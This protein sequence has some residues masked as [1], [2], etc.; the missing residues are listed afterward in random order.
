[1]NPNKVLNE[2]EIGESIT[3]LFE[4]EEAINLVYDG[5]S[6][7]AGGERVK[8]FV[9]EDTDTRYAI[10]ENEL[11]ENISIN[12]IHIRDIAQ[13]LSKTVEEINS[14]QDYKIITELKKNDALELFTEDYAEDAPNIWEYD[15]DSDELH[16]ISKTIIDASFD[17]D[18][19]S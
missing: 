19:I 8:L 4:T 1:M 16:V 7:V 9:T 3:L 13:E 18:K 11:Q 5:S 14:T 15:A 6:I 12:L 2:S 17:I 10:R